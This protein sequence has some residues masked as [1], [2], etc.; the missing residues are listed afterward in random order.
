ME[1]AKGRGRRMLSSGK[2]KVCHVGLYFLA[3]VWTEDWYPPSRS[4][5]MSY[6]PCPP[7]LS[8]SSVS[9]LGSPAKAEVTK[10]ELG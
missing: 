6:S 5:T 9:C 7:A 10:Y 1:V 2:Y 4:S 3:G 8:E